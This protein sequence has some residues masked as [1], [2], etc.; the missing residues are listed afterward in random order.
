VLAVTCLLAARSLPSCG[1]RYRLHGRINTVFFILTVTALL[2]LEVIIRIL[3][4][5]ISTVTTG[6]AAGLF[7]HLC[8][9]AGGPAATVHALDR[10]NA[11]ALYLTLRSSSQCSGGNG[12]DGVFF[13]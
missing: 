10:P 4:P 1:Q 7:V 2:A 3:D 5:S 11:A 12:R 8:F 9:G 13:L 6:M